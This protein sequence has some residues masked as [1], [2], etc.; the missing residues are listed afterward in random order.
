MATHKRTS[1]ERVP[2]KP[3]TKLYAATKGEEHEKHTEGGSK[4]DKKTIE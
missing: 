1:A 4:H 2:T 3:K